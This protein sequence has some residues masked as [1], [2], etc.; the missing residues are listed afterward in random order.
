M[1]QDSKVRRKLVFKLPRN[2][3]SRGSAV[4]GHRPTDNQKCISFQSLTHLQACMMSATHQDTMKGKHPLCIPF[5]HRHRCLPLRGRLRAEKKKLTSRLQAKTKGRLALETW[6]ILMQALSPMT[7]T[8]KGSLNA[9]QLA[10]RY[11]FSGLVGVSWSS[12]LM[13][14]STVFKANHFYLSKCFADILGW[15]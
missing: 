5:S 6:L 3:Q 10:L 13:Q 9:A 4:L 7:R 2:Q 1:D 15:H 14:H 11:A 8:L 12:A